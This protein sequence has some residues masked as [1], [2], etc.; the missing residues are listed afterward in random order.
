MTAWQIE[1]SDQVQNDIKEVLVRTREQFGDRKY[2]QY[3]ELIRLVLRE[4]ASDPNNIRVKKRPEIHESARTCH[5][6]RAGKRARHFF[7][8][9]VLEGQAVEVG[10]LLYDGM[11]ISLHLPTEYQP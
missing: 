1:L 2:E 4:I 8:F 11:D 10:R 6:A 5:L 3:R 7:L 9:R